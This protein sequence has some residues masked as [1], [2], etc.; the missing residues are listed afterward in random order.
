MSSACHIVLFQ[1][2]PYFLFDH[3]LL[4]VCPQMW[5]KYL[6]IFKYS[7]SHFPFD[8]SRLHVVPPWTLHK[9]VFFL[10]TL[11]LCFHRP[12]LWYRTSHTTK[13]KTYSRKRGR[14][15]DIPRIYFY[16]NKFSFHRTMIWNRQGK[17]QWLKSKYIVMGIVF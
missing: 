2:I 6:Y 14:N 3:P 7:H 16:M 15:A 17:H 9:C 1:I 5:N 10:L 8:T 11:S 4:F 13:Q 12:G